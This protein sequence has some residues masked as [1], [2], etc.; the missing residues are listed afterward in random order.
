MFTEYEELKERSFANVFT[1]VR[2]AQQLT[3]AKLTESGLVIIQ[4][5]PRCPECSTILT[6]DFLKGV[7]HCSGCDTKWDV[8]SLIE[9]LRNE[10]AVAKLY[11]EETDDNKET[12]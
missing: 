9:A 12:D 6:H 7:W 8:T 11:E 3:E 1:G 2:W 4:G 10:R 5:L